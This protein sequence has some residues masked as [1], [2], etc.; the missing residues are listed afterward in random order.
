MA[1]A[2][3]QADVLRGREAMEAALALW[4]AAFNDL[5]ADIREYMERGDFVVCDARWHGR[6]K[7][8]GVA[9]DMRPLGISRRVIVSGTMGFRSKTEALEA[10]GLVD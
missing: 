7:D 8:S 3:D 10:A 1:N 2:P 9:L 6:A 5:R 4:T